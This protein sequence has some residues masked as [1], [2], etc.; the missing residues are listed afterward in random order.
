MKKF[1]TLIMMVAIAALAT[2]SL[3][4][5]SGRYFSDEKGTSGGFFADQVVFVYTDNDIPKMNSSDG[6]E[7]LTSIAAKKVCQEPEISDMIKND[8]VS[9]IYIYL[10]KKSSD[11]LIMVKVDHCN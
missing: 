8:G 10:S 4:A 2:T 6:I 1:I 3:Q 9:I 5:N 7:L 11:G